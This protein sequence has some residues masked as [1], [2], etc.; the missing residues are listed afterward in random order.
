MAFKPYDTSIRPG[1]TDLQYY[2]RLA[3]VADQRLKRLED[4]SKEGDWKDAQ[5]FAYQRAQEALKLYGEGKP[6]K[7]LRFNANIPD[8]VSERRFFNEKTADLIH[9][10][11]AP[12]STKSGITNVYKQRADTLNKKF[13]T[14]L[15]WSDL[16][17]VF[18]NMQGKGAPGSYKTLSAIGLI[19]NVKKEGIE[20][21]RKKNKH[22]DD[23]IVKDVAKHILTN[24]GRKWQKT[25]NALGL[26]KAEREELK[27]FIDNL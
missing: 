15:S 20:E 16:G 24:K 6:G 19:Q 1:E 25:L 7:G 10:L 3:K 8:P 11:E 17:R 18:E 5:R 27:A 26:K 4:L 12:T 21:A 13:G 22:F 2:K 23:D 14:D 9:F